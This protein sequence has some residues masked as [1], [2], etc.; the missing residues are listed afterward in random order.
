MRHNLIKIG[1][2]IYLLICITPAHAFMIEATSNNNNPYSII[3]ASV[4]DSQNILPY[5]VNESTPAH[6]F[7][8]SVNESFTPIKVLDYTNTTKDTI[9]SP[10]TIYLTRILLILL[11][12]TILLSTFYVT[13]AT[14]YANHIGEIKLV[15]NRADIAFN[16]YMNMYYGFMP[17]PGDSDNPLTHNEVIWE[18]YHYADFRS[19]Q[20][21]FVSMSENHYLNDWINLHDAPNYFHGNLI[22]VPE[23]PRVFQENRW[24]N[25]C[26]WIPSIYG[27]IQHLT[28]DYQDDYYQLV[29]DYGNIHNLMV[30]YKDAMDMYHL[31]TSLI[32][33]L[34][35]MIILADRKELMGYGSIKS[36]NIKNT[37]FRIEN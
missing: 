7:N 31:S 3:G 1:I 33:H 10:A 28:L 5:D 30:G 23:E 34:L 12:I 9:Q 20:N 36:C 6:M 4:Q 32:I 27:D 26:E 17:E 22:P 15:K 18:V 14:I 19:H 37:V 16:V 29:D 8:I 25:L 21:E 2:C 24:G 13:R 11:A 35:I